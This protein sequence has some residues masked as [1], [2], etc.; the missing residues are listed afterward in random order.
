[1][2]KLLILILLVFA[3]DCGSSTKQESSQASGASNTI[4]SQVCLNGQGLYGACTSCNSGYTLNGGFCLLPCQN[5]TGIY[6]ACSSCN[7]GLF[8]SGGF[9]LTT[10]SLGIPSLS[11][12]PNTNQVQ[13]SIVVIGISSLSAS[14]NTYSETTLAC[15]NG[16][17][18]SGGCYACNTGYTLVRGYC[19]WGITTCKNGIGTEGACT[20]CNQD[21]VLVRGYCNAKQICPNGIPGR[22]V[23][24]SPQQESCLS[25]NSGY[26]LG[27]YSCIRNTCANGVGTDGSEFFSYGCFTC[28]EG[29]TRVATLT[30]YNSQVNYCSN[31]PCQNGSGVEGACNTCNSGYGLSN[32]YC[33]TCENGM[34]PYNAC[35][36]CNSGYTVN[37]GVCKPICTNGTGTQGLCTSCNTGY[38]L[39]LVIWATTN[40]DNL[41][42]APGVYCGQTG[43][44]CNNGAG[45]DGACTSCTDG[46]AYIFENGYCKRRCQYGS[47][48]QGACSNCYFGYNLDNGLCKPS[49]KN[50]AGLNGACTSCNSG[51]TLNSGYCK[52]PCT[53]GQ[54]FSGECTSCNSGYTS[55]S[56]NNGIYCG[57]DNS[58]CTN[59]TGLEGAC[60]YCTY[61][62]GILAM[63]LAMVIASKVVKMVIIMHANGECTYCNYG[64]SL[65]NGYCK[66]NCQNGIGVNGSCMSC[67]TG[68]T[69]N[70]GYCLSSCK[71]GQG[72]EKGLCSSCDSGYLLIFGY[73]W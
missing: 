34:G 63:F 4:N 5:G 32:G 24:W 42:V 47:G 48:V 11:A 56:V 39:S 69:L 64:Y 30:I 17:G 53:N 38:T 36:T 20:S 9:C 68:Y 57:L 26:F 58:S 25:C 21:Y 29:Y 71:N 73:C 43:V 14:P 59:G 50:G 62:P 67:N 55:V 33:K 44:N 27:G 54:G 66:P 72:L 40:N 6:G 70:N 12:S 18:L 19:V 46:G 22:P 13:V 51:Y 16:Q 8:L 49:C 28:N 41:I 15:E 10:S 2:N 31:A 65:V 60:N 61:N 23:L 3:I 7:Y 37:K 52:L 45:L 35:T 1:M